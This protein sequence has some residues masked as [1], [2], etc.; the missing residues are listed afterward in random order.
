MGAVGAFMA[1]DPTDP[2]GVGGDFALGSGAGLT[3]AGEA[4]LGF[5]R[6]GG[7]FAA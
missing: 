4:A 7:E 1:V 6:G 2:A 3:L 5:A